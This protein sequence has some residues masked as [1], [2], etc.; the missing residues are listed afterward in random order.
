MRTF[1][2]AVITI[3]SA[4]AAHAQK[5]MADLWINLPDSLTP[6]LNSDK[7]TDMVNFYKMGVDAEVPSLLDEKSELRTLQE[8]YLRARL[9][10]SSSLQ[11]V[12]WPT[13]D[14]DTVIVMVNTYVGGTLER[15]GAAESVVNFYNPQWQKFDPAD[16]STPV[17]A[18][19]LLCKPDTMDQQEYDRLLR[20]AH[21]AMVAVDIDEEDYS[22]IYRLYVP[23]LTNQERD[24]IQ[25]IFVQRKLKWNGKKYN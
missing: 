2:I 16:V 14:S 20:L 10:E 5:T 4:L 21:P 17:T 7:R 13:A 18:S 23:M 25:P 1:C 22:L 12:M 19:D 6:Y 15:G 11:M 9:S 8:R 3:L 24:Q